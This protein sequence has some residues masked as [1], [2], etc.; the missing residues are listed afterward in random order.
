M[1][2]GGIVGG[3]VLG[4]GVLGGGGVVVCPGVC[5]FEPFEPLPL[6]QLTSE[7]ATKNRTQALKDPRA[8]RIG[9]SHKPQFFVCY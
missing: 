7:H 6:E 4:G 9:A 8:P 1:L 2:G 5:G 3:G